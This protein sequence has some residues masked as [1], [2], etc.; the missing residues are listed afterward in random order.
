MAHR[1][2]PGAAD[3]GTPPRGAPGGDAVPAPARGSGALRAARRAV[4]LVALVVLVVLVVVRREQVGEVVSG[5]QPAWLAAALL[6]SVGQLLA[7][8][9]IWVVALRALRTPVGLRASFE[10]TAGAVAARYLPGS[11]L[12][13]AARVVALRRS[14][15]P[16]ATLSAVAALEMLLVPAVG[17]VLGVLLLG[18]TAVGA[19]ASVPLLLAGAVAAVLAVPPLLNLGLRLLGRRTGTPPA[20]LRPGVVLRTALCVVAYWVSAATVVLLYLRAFDAP[21]DDVPLL[22]A[23][24]AYVL[25]WT[26]GWLAVVAPQGVGVVEVTFAALVSAVAPG[27]DAASLVVVLAGYRL[28]VLVRDVAV[29][30]AVA[31]TRVIRRRRG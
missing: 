31:A 2:S 23:A 4:A 14:G 7:T 24:G 10:A 20:R 18:S 17:A 11:V 12:Y 19:A 1:R 25:A 3:E 13:A 30:A 5:A 28:L 26:L 16:A 21:G 27:T 6:G 15:V 9:L 8:S 22:H 29:T